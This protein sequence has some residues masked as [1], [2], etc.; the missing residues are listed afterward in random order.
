[1]VLFFLSFFL[2][3]HRATDFNLHFCIKN[4][5]NCDEEFVAPFNSNFYNK[6]LCES[7]V[8]WITRFTYLLTYYYSFLAH[9][10]KKCFNINWFHLLSSAILS[11]WYSRF[12][13][14]WLLRDDSNSKTHVRF[15]Y[16]LPEVLH[17]DFFIWNKIFIQPRGKYFIYI[18][19]KCY[20]LLWLFQLRWTL[21]QHFQVF[22]V[23]KP[24]TCFAVRVISKEI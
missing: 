8:M 24:N 14:T 20:F 16:V 1:M 22:H 4:L 11:L 2:A 12:E 13:V 10:N 15:V 6:M 21:F 9:Y 18:N 7:G 17:G 23:N 19:Q 5:L 3:D